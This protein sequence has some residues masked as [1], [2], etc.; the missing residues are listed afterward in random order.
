MKVKVNVNV[1]PKIRDMLVGLK[2]KLVDFVS[3]LGRKIVAVLYLRGIVRF[4]KRSARG[5]LDFFGNITDRVKAF[6]R[7]C[8]RLV[9]RCVDA[10]KD[11]LSDF[12]ANVKRIPRH[13]ARLLRAVLSWRPPQ[14]TWTLLISLGSMYLGWFLIK[15]PATKLATGTSFDWET[16]LTVGWLF[17]GLGMLLAGM[18]VFLQISSYRKYFWVGLVCS[19]PV[20][21]VIGYQTLLRAQEMRLAEGVDRET[22]ERW[23][24]GLVQVTSVFLGTAVLAF[25]CLRTRLLR[26]MMCYGGPGT[27]GSAAFGAVQGAT[28]AYLVWV[29]FRWLGFVKDIG[30]FVNTVLEY[31]VDLYIGCG[32]VL[33]ALISGYF[34]F[35]RR[36]QP[37]EPVTG[38]VNGLL[39]GSGA[40]YLTWILFQWLYTTKQ[41][42]WCKT[43]LDSSRIEYFIGG[44]ALLF[45]AVAVFRGVRAQRS[46]AP[47]GWKPRATSGG[48]RT[49]RPTVSSATRTAVSSGTRSPGTRPVAGGGTRSAYGSGTQSAGTQSA[50][51][52]SSGTQSSGTQSSGTQSSGGQ[53]SGSLTAIDVDDLFD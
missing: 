3:A 14:R 40:G 12:T 52:Q 50:G 44:G 24:S 32:A 53:S 46:G 49:A 9:R 10:V 22:L 31:P 15:G 5:V 35:R 29:G 42:A 48:T 13:L 25:F 30:W 43:V 4:F 37:T 27:V 20:A 2:D 11:F 36:L 33:G 26:S 19:V 17:T 47:S 23:V 18:G 45:C 39:V 34:G 1:L 6:V 28:L 51:T 8:S 7:A 21:C 41:M 16:L 38:G